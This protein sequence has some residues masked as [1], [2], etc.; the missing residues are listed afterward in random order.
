M[1]FIRC[2]KVHGHEY[3]QVVRN[4]REG[5]KHRQ[6]VLDHLR[7]HHSVE[8]A[9][10]FRKRKLTSHLE[11]ATALSKRA[12]D[13]EADLQ[14]LYSDDLGGK[15]PSEE[16]AW[17]KYDTLWGK[18][19][20]TDHADSPHRFGHLYVEGLEIELDRAVR[21]LDYYEL[22]SQ[23]DQERDLARRWQE[24]LNRLLNIQATYF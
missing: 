23:A 10:A 18:L 12:E 8:A 11:R 5:G 19:S 7:A 20:W 21:T 3:Y 2:K 9:I 22:T 14:E 16:E 24:K 15:I 4:Y 6:E 1:A 17:E 13:L